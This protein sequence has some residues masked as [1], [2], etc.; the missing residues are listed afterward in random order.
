MCA[1]PTAAVPPP[2]PNVEEVAERAYTLWLRD[3]K[4]DGRDLDHW[5]EAER[6]L[7]EERARDAA[8][9]DLTTR[10][11]ETDKRVDGLAPLRLDARTPK[12][13]QL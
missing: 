13:E 12:G 6:L 10:D 1:S 4:P 11:V 9:R 7:R 3:G 8:A 2:A 5:H